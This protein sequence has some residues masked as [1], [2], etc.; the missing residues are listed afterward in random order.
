MKKGKKVLKGMTLIEMIIT[1]AVLAMLC[2]ILAMVGQNIDATTRA[3]NNL[4]DKVVKES[5]YAANA[6]NHYNDHAGNNVELA[7]EAG[8][9]VVRI[10]GSFEFDGISYPDPSVNIGVERYNTEEIVLD[11]RSVQE[12]KVIQ[13]GPNSGINFKFIRFTTSAPAAPVTTTTTVAA[14]VE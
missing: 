1:I 2:V 4:K 12:R 9:V 5:P 10:N 7:S 8:T 3:T 14:P 11:G 13:E 6:V